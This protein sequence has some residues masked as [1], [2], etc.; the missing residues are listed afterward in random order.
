MKPLAS[1]RIDKL[2]SLRPRTYDL[3]AFTFRLFAPFLFL[4]KGLVLV[5]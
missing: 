2:I 3:L 1:T 4:F 5:G